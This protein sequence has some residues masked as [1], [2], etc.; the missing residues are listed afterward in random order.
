MVDVFGPAE[1]EFAE[2]EFEHLEMVVLLIAHH[3]DEFV[4]LVF[5]EASLRRAQVLGHIYRG[6][7]TAQQEFAVQ[8]VR[9]EV[10][11]N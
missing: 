2:N 8:P 3:I 5:V 11:P 4:Q 6:A 10:A 1:T 9:R 7:V